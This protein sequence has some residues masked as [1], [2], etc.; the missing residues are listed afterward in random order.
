L[1]NRADREEHSLLVDWFK[2]PN[3]M[4]RADPNSGPAF[5]YD[6]DLTGPPPQVKDAQ[7]EDSENHK[8]ASPAREP[9]PT[10]APTSQ[11]AAKPEAETQPQ[12]TPPV[13]SSAPSPPEPPSPPAT[14]YITVHRTPDHDADYR[15]LSRIH[16]LLQTEKGEDEFIIRLENGGQTVE[17]SFPNDQTHCTPMLQQQIREIVGRQN[18]RVVNRPLST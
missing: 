12:R 4:L 8:V 16:H 1:D 17:L 5:T 2:D 11:P 18:L 10:S 13:K 6:A 15:K 9:E 7:S 14:L 3:E